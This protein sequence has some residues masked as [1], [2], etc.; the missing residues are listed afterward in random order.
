MNTTTKLLTVVHIQTRGTGAM[1][2]FGMIHYCYNEITK[3]I[4]KRSCY[5][6]SQMITFP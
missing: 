6:R 4:H 1:C 5:A 2:F 3:M